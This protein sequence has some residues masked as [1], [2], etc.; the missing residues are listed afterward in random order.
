MA[1]YVKTGNLLAAAFQVNGAPLARAY[2]K[3]RTLVFPDGPQTQPLRVMS[4]NVG[5]W[6]S[7][8]VNATTENQGFWYPLQNAIFEQERA[9]LCGIQEYYNAIGSYS[10][11]TMLEQYFRYLFTVNKSSKKA[12]RAICSVYP[13]SNTQEINFQNQSGEIRS[14]LIGDVTIGGKTVKFL[15]AHLALV[16]A[17]I[18]L[19]IQELLQAVSGFDYWILTGDFNIPFPNKESSG[20]QNLIKPFLDAGYHVANGS[21]FGFIPTFSTKAPGDDS[22]WRVLDN[23]MCSA[24]IDITDVYVDT[25]KLTTL[26][27]QGIDHLPLIA[28]M[29]IN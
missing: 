14:Y 16:T 12:G 11:P 8:G 26:T 28:N 24:N 25:E 4:Y 15:T 6:T 22:D 21:T 1:I 18:I 10:V 29:V 27:T 2:S 20:Y 23:I 5:S 3:D 13:M 17:T 9:D 7:F 19:Q